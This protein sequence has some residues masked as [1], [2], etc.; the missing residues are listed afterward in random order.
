MVMPHHYEIHSLKMANIV[1]SML[2]FPAWRPVMRIKTVP[3][4]IDARIVLKEYFLVYFQFLR[5]FLSW[6]RF[7][8]NSKT[9]IN[10]KSLFDNTSQTRKVVN[11]WIWLVGNFWFNRF[12]RLYVFGDHSGRLFGLSPDFFLF[13]FFMR[14]LDKRISPGLFNSLLIGAFFLAIS[15]VFCV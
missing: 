9:S 2:T 7:W 5:L 8:L 13:C 1:L 4:V 3:A 14:P 12:S 15:T 11:L 10:Q 6:L